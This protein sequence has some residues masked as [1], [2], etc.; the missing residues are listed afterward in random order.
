MSTMLGIKKE[1]SKNFEEE[2]ESYISSLEQFPKIQLEKT[3]VTKGLNGQLVDEIKGNNL[4]DWTTYTF[5]KYFTFQNKQYLNKVDDN[6]DDD[7]NTN[8]IKSIQQLKDKIKDI[9]ASTKENDNVSVSQSG[10]NLNKP[11]NDVNKVVNDWMQ[12]P[13]PNSAFEGLDILEVDQIYR[14]FLLNSDK[15]IVNNLK[16]LL[17]KIENEKTNLKI[18]NENFNLLKPSLIS[19]GI[20]ELKSLAGSYNKKSVFNIIQQINSLNS[21][22]EKIKDSF[23]KTLKIEEEKIWGPSNT[24][25]TYWEEIQKKVIDSEREK[26]KLVN[27]FKND[28]DHL[29]PKFSDYWNDNVASHIKKGKKKKNTD[30]FMKGKTDEEILEYM[31]KT[32]DDF[33]TNTNTYNQKW[34]DDVLLKSIE[35][36]KSMVGEIQE[37]LKQSLTQQKERLSEAVNNSTDNKDSYQA[38]LQRCQ[39]QLEKC[40]KIQ[41]NW[42][43]RIN[44]FL[45]NYD[46]TQAK[47][48]GQFDELNAEYKKSIN[49]TGR[50][51]TVNKKDFM[52]Q[53]KS[54]ESQANSSRSKDITNDIF[55]INDMEDSIIDTLMIL[56][57]EGLLERKK[58]VQSRSITLQENQK[59]TDL[60]AKRKDILE[61]CQN[62]I[63][64]GFIYMG[65]KLDSMFI[66]ESCR[67]SE[68]SLTFQKLGISVT[69]S[70]K[71][72]KKANKKKKKAASASATAS[73]TSTPETQSPQPSPKLEE[74]VLTEPAVEEKEIKSEPIVKEEKINNNSKPTAIPTPSKATIAENLIKNS[75]KA[76][77]NIIKNET[78][79]AEKQPAKMLFTDIVNKPV[80]LEN[81]IVM[82]PDTPPSEATTEKV[83]PAKKLKIKQINK[84]AEE[85]PKETT[86]PLKSKP[87]TTKP[88]PKPKEPKVESTP[89][90]NKEVVKE[91]SLPKEEKKEVVKE[92]EQPKEEKEE[93]KEVEQPKEVVKEEQS[94]VEAKEEENPVEEQPKE[95]KK[96]V[97]EEQKKLEEE[98][99][100]KTETENSETDTPQPEKDLVNEEVFT[101]GATTK[102]STEGFNLFKPHDEKLLNNALNPET[103]SSFVPFPASITNNANLTNSDSTN[104]DS[105]FSTAATATAAAA[106]VSPHTTSTPPGL[107]ISTAS[108]LN[109]FQPMTTT[110]F[111]MDSLLANISIPPLTPTMVDITSHPQSNEQ[112]MVLV[113]R[114][115]SENQQL[116]LTLNK[117]MQEMQHFTNQKYQEASTMAVEYNRLKLQ[118]IEQQHRTSTLEDELN[119]QKMI[120][121]EKEHTI[122]TLKGKIEEL[123]HHHHHH[124]NGGLGGRNGSRSGSDT[125]N[126]Y[127]PPKLRS[128]SGTAGEDG[129]SSSKYNPKERK[130]FP[131]AFHHYNKHG[132]SNS[133]EKTGSFQSSRSSSYNSKFTF[134]NKG[135]KPPGLEHNGWRKQTSKGFSSSSTSGTHA[136][137]KEEED[138]SIP[139][140]NIFASLN[141][142][143]YESDSGDE[144]MSH[145]NEEESGMVQ[146]PEMMNEGEGEGEG[147]EEGEEEGEGEEIHD[148]KLPSEEEAVAEAVEADAA[149]T[150]PVP[151]MI[152]EPEPMPEVEGTTT[153]AAEILG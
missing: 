66:E 70:K 74:K 25:L 41:D 147:E 141:D 79:M 22:I 38:L 152:P 51:E 87:S 8:A 81:K 18:N 84:S 135:N 24:I 103:S 7:K 14:D 128:N 5:Q 102:P 89:A 121:Q 118:L 4:K 116:K 139:T 133:S 78:K 146:E 122:E 85:K 97:I 26:R 82:K 106:A 57:D 63:I 3:T 60:V 1:F 95:E 153:S 92:V 10:L 105:L 86:P 131:G 61:A 72:K 145:E 124:Y 96:E 11:L 127:R 54:I 19:E 17:E 73:A 59:Y 107:D 93:I 46:E 2:S 69:S 134:G 117:L 9:V 71:N 115:Q 144:S 150:Q 132:S 113:N 99:T 21:I 49:L 12:Q 126:V 39:S 30:N 111:S 110:T 100:K 112:L 58:S 83:I 138:H 67:M 15:P 62:E 31:D 56:L 27:I 50:L 114:L 91:V 98:L 94:K 88:T 68:T 47:W 53:I 119:I 35:V 140:S 16:E 65:I 137:K 40:L 43:E 104:V 143:E 109:N 42:Q 33:F 120:Q 90:S 55:T 52:K 48:Q 151:A 6:E 76:S 45:K 64:A 34:K 125:G 36:Q 123:V 130:G 20:E 108:L 142:E 75:I 148:D 149:E 32:F 13:L 37:Q 44:L 129:S 80:P 101:N 136:V 23:D 28:N 29:I 77:E